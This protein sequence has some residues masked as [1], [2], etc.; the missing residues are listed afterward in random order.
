[1]P[2]PRTITSPNIMSHLKSAA[3]REHLIRP[4]TLC[5]AGLVLPPWHCGYPRY[6]GPIREFLIVYTGVGGRDDHKIKS[7]DGWS[8]PRHGFGPRPLRV[9]ARRADNRYMRIVIG[10]DGAA[11]RKFFK[12][13]ITRRLAF[14]VNIGLIG[15]TKDKNSAPP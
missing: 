5:L 8:G 4:S 14:I 2:Q 10:D 7:R 3:K 12:Q 13:S 15:K 11:L 6:L 1:M 9:F